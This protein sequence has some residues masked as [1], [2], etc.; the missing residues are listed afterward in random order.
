MEN[1]LKNSSDSGYKNDSF[2]P[3]KQQT[4]KSGKGPL[5][6][7]LIAGLA[8]LIMFV[9]L[10]YDWGINRGGFEDIAGLFGKKSK[11]IVKDKEITVE[12]DLPEYNEYM[13]TAGADIDERDIVREE[14]NIEQPEVIQKPQQ[15][16]S[17]PE[18]AKPK[19]NKPVTPKQT[20]DSKVD[21]EKVPYPDNITNRIQ[22]SPVKE[23]D[24]LFTVQVYAT[25]SQDDA[26][27]WKNKLLNQNIEDV[28]ISAMKIK[29]RDW[30]RVRFGTF[31]SF[32]EAR[33]AAMKS[34]FAHSWIDRVK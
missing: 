23:S 1:D 18:P 30:F 29:N 3:D 27:A 13:D 5:M 10:I 25:P 22:K 34:G 28:N 11:E 26:E 20:H 19:E 15:K 7:L 33:K 32:D 31:K 6:V 14:E 24:Q 17:N 4:N 9:S 2:L 12:K 16:L 21:L 8:V